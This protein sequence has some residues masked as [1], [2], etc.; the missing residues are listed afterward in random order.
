VAWP[1]GAA[2]STSMNTAPVIYGGMPGLYFPSI[3]VLRSG[4]GR[5]QEYGEFTDALTG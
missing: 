5:N 2:G 3:T 1:I 4:R